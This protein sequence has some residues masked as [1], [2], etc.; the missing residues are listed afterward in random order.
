VIFPDWSVD[1]DDLGWELQQVI[2][3]LANHKSKITLLI[4]VGDTSAEEADI[5]LAAIAMNLMMEAE[6][7]ITEELTISLIIDLN[8]I[9]WENLIPRINARVSLQHEN[10]KVIVNKQ[11]EQI[12][13]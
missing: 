11:V 3:I 6:I 13:L 4:D 7:D 10:Q 9:Q 8:E 5:V 12:P 1:E 2:Q